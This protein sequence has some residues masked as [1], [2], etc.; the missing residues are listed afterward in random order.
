MPKELTPLVKLGLL[1]V[2]VILI[3]DRFITEVPDLIVIPVLL[4]AIVLIL[5]GG[6]RKKG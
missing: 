2:V 6:W 4:L 5:I 3:T 1:V